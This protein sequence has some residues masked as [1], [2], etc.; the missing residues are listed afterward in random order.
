MRTHT[1]TTS[2]KRRLVAAVGVAMLAVPLAACGSSDSGAPQPVA[3]V[4]SLT[5]KTTSIALDKG[6]TD[7]LT[8]LKLTAGTVG[9]AQLQDGSLIFPITGGSVRVFKKGEVVP[10]VIGEIQ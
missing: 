3:R 10:Y 4:D 8:S 5:G 6:F 9:T 7:A 2:T 1:L